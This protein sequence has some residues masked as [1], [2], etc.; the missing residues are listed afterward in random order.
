MKI[1]YICTHNRCRSILSEAITNHLS[2][3]ELHAFSAGS[4]PAERVHPLALQYLAEHGIATQGLESK[5]WDAFDAQEVDIVVTVCDSAAKE[6]CPVWFGG[7]V[8]AHWS[9]PDPSQLDGSAA[10][11]REAFYAVMATIAQRTRRLLAANLKGLTVAQRQAA[12]ETLS[13]EQ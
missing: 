13:A 1:L 3:G 8:T 2:R 7:A 6:A 10:E 5:S 4:Q 9:L 12:L 11:V